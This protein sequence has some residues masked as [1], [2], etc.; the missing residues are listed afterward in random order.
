MFD[1]SVGISGLFGGGG[2]ARGKEW[3]GE[4]TRNHVPTTHRRKVWQHQDAETHQRDAQEWWVTQRPSD[5][6]RGSFSP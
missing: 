3:Q 5:V 6:K 1:L 4:K 2:G